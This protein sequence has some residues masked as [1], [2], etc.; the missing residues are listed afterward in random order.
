MRR[1]ASVAARLGGV[2]DCSP[3]VEC[4]AALVEAHEDLLAAQGAGE[5]ERLPALLRELDGH[6]LALGAHLRALR[7]GAGPSETATSERLLA[8]V[9]T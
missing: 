3:I 9:R 5:A 1:S 4:A 6:L 7:S 2:A 8:K